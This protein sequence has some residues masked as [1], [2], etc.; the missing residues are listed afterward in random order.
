MS[1][2]PLATA[3][4]SFWSSSLATVVVVAACALIVGAGVVIVLARRSKRGTVRE[5]VG[6]FV[7]G[8]QPQ[9]AGSASKQEDIFMRLARPFERERWWGELTER[10][11]LARIDRAPLEVV[12]L[13]VLAALVAAALAVIVA[14]SVPLGVIAFLV[15]PLAARA[16]LNKAVER[17]RLLFCEQLPAHLQELAAA[18][19]AGH[20]MVSGIGVMAESASEPTQS[21]FRRVLADEQLGA[22]LEEAMRSVAV[23]M[24]TRDMEQVAL[25]AELH[26]QTGGNMAEVLDRVAESVRARSELTL[27]LRTLT[28][29]ARGSRW[30]VTSIPP[31]LLG[32][33]YLLNPRYL[34]SLFNTSTGQV[35]LCVAAGLIVLGSVVMGRI[36]NI[37]A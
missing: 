36:V 31:I 23:R 24:R 10:L 19:R 2:A 30:I 21:E 32:L 27:E 7:S 16:V 33:I 9:E 18:L 8:E 17:Q 4:S 20:S 29:Q 35:L 1:L 26:R 15:V 12:N 3:H 28:A 34:D 14:H 22:P 5:R 37:E 6:E 25:V 13:T 11:D